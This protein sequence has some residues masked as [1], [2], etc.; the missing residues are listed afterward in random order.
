MAGTIFG[1]FTMIPSLLWNHIH[2]V[3]H[4]LVGNLSRRRTNPELWTLTVNE[5]KNASI[6][7]KIGYR[8]MRSYFM[9]LIVTPAIWIL[10]PR[11]P[12]PHLGLKI[13]TS[14]IIHDLI[15]VIILYFI[16]KNDLFFAFTMI[17][18]VPLYMFNFLA[19]V[20]FYLQH[21]YEDTF[22]ETEEEWDLYNASIH[23]S[24]HLVVG[25][26][27]GWVSGHVGC[28]HVH[29]LNTKIPSY[30]LYTATEDV[31]QHLDIKPIYMKE[32]F[33]HLSCVLWDEEAKKLI[34]IRALKK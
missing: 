20:F 23:G 19:S 27:M 17:Y 14:V 12:L 22:W 26:V 29:H 25:K 28:H 32:I 33:Y 34:S 5:Y 9:R 8:I 4:G 3:H 16:I 18:L 15:Y 30:N 31:N 24:S 11:I 10:A 6:G 21:Q 7:K 2:D 1:F 13:L